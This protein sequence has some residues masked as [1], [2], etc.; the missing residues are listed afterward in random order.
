MYN[1]EVVAI[2]TGTLFIVSTPI[3]NLKDITHRSLELLNSVDLIAAED[4][5]RTGI[6]LK[7]YEIKTPLSSFNSYNQ[8]KKSK[9][10]ASSL[11]QQLLICHQPSRQV[12]FNVFQGCGALKKY[13]FRVGNFRIFSWKST[14]FR[15]GNSFFRVEPEPNY[16]IFRVETGFLWYSVL[17]SRVHSSDS[18]TFGMP[19]TAST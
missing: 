17:A 6:L 13:F 1:K 16:Q 18:C 11:N 19:Y 4:T 3:G 5:R 12:F 8:V 9:P 14:F 2:S 10:S 7:H 15:V